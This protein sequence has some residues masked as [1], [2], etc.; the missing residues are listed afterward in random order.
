M[1]NALLA[2]GV[3]QRLNNMLLAD[4]VLERLGSP[5]AV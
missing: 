2:Y 3:L 1:R 5:G 4:H